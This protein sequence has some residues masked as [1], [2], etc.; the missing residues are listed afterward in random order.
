[1]QQRFTFLCVCLC[2]V[3]FQNYYGKDWITYEMNSFVS[4]DFVNPPIYL[5]N[6]Y[7]VCNYTAGLIKYKLQGKARYITKIK[8]QKHIYS[9]F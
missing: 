7:Y 4:T 2:G 1:M 9:C 8:Q 5:L 3:V 6:N